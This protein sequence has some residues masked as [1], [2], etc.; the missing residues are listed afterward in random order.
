[1]EG[2][3]KA[4]QHQLRVGDRR[5]RFELRLPAPPVRLEVDPEFDVFRRLD[6]REIPPALTQAFGARRALMVLPAA[7]P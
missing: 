6:R 3:S 5:D 2:Q 7:A 4:Y 1:M